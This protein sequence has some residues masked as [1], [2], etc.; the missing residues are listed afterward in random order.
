MT[1]LANFI[2]LSDHLVL[3]LL[4]YWLSV[5]DLV[6]LDI[7]FSNYVLRLRYLRWL[8]HNGLIYSN[9]FFLSERIRAYAILEWIRWRDISTVDFAI[10]INTPAYNELRKAEF[11]TPYT[12]VKKLTVRYLPDIVETHT[13]VNRFKYLILHRFPNVED[14]VLLV[15]GPVDKYLAVLREFAST[16]HIKKLHLSSSLQSPLSLIELIRIFGCR[17]EHLETDFH[18]NED[19]LKSLAAHCPNMTH[20]PS[21]ISIL[22]PSSTFPKMFH[23]MQH[24]LSLH[25]ISSGFEYVDEKI[26]LLAKHMPQLR[27]IVIIDSPM[28]RLTAKAAVYVL[29]TCVYIEHFSLRHVVW[30]RGTRHLC[31]TIGAD[32]LLH[33]D[34]LLECVTDLKVL[35]IRQLSTCILDNLPVFFATLA[36]SSHMN[37]LASMILKGSVL[38]WLCGVTGLLPQCRRITHL[39]VSDCTGMLISLD[40]MFE[41]LF[42]YG[43]RLVSLSLT[44]LES[45]VDIEVHALVD[46]MPDL[47]RLSIFHCSTLSRDVLMYLA[48]DGRVWTCLEFR[49]TRI[50]RDDVMW[51]MQKYGLQ[52]KRI[53]CTDIKTCKVECDVGYE[54]VVLSSAKVPVG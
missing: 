29:K 9:S 41:N 1:S 20:I 17:L 33:L 52:C 43:S 34:E 48:R 5:N 23:S 6:G 47:T 25:L 13:N 18:M 21:S 45:L 11:Q 26:A 30:H 49:E 8:R 44:N 3:N 32:P 31:L 14:L 40:S 16:L 54:K 10:D 2:A 51:A 19:T 24:L 53:V 39:A 7:A 15:A 38:T 46:H 50:T 42:L 12:F 28:N 36:I 27:D 37:T 35:E 22:V 4:Q